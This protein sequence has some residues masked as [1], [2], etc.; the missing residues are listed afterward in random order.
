MQKGHTYPTY[1]RFQLDLYA[2]APQ[3]YRHDVLQIRFKIVLTYLLTILNTQSLSLSLSL[4]LSFFLP[5]DWHFSRSS[6]VLGT[7]ENIKA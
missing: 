3:F 7:Y 5:L 1:R 2:K 4:S 6:P